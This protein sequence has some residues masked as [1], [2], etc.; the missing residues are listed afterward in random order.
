MGE[1]ARVSHHPDVPSKAIHA[2]LKFTILELSAP[3]FS[4]F[5]ISRVMRSTRYPGV[6]NSGVTIGSLPGT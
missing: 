1:W 6:R 4:G 3:Y 5:G 2:R